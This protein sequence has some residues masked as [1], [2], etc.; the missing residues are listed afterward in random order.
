MKEDLLA[1]LQLVP[2]GHLKYC[3]FHILFVVYPISILPLASCQNPM[4]FIHVCCFWLVIQF[5]QLF[6]VQ[7]LV[8]TTCL[9]WLF[10]L[11]HGFNSHFPLPKTLIFAAR[12][13]PGLCLWPICLGNHAAAETR[14]SLAAGGREKNRG[15]AMGTWLDHVKALFSWLLKLQVVI[16]KPWR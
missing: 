14:T 3:C 4:I 11:N 2:L 10:K 1:Q 6:V 5:H 12:T 15:H 9:S 13:G 7:W 16:V 8:R